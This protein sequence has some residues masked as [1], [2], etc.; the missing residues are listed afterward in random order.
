MEAINLI[1]AE[2]G[3]WRQV[4]RINERAVAGSIIT[5]LAISVASFFMVLQPTQAASLPGLEEG[6]L[7][8]LTNIE[9]QAQGLKPLRYNPQLSRAAEAKAADMLAADYF[10]HTSPAGKTPWSF[11]KATGYDYYKAGENLAIDFTTVEGPI[12][13]WMASPSHRANIL[14][15]DFSEIGIASMTGEYQGR[16]TTVVV[17]MFGTKS[18]STKGL[19]ADLT[20]AFSQ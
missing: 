12:P 6:R 7:I 10:E 3:V 8:E 11:I 9:R 19:L 15:E 16:E 1:T 17:Q 4:A 14:K 18:L 5:A 20:D 2:Y 13:A